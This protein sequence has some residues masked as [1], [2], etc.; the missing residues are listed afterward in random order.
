[1]RRKKQT[2]W[3]TRENRRT[4]K[5]RRRGIRRNAEIWEG[6]LKTKKRRRLSTD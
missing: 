1:M 6:E 3:L 5:C 2:G 4:A